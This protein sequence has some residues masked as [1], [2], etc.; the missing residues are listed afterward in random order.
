MDTLRVVIENLSELKSSSTANWWDYLID[1]GPILIAIIGMWFSYEQFKKSLSQSHDQFKKSFNNNLLQKSI[2][3]RRNEIYKKLNEFYGPL[4]Q[5][6][7][8]SQR[9]YEIFRKN[10]Y[11]KDENFRSLDYLLKGHKFNP[12]EKNLLIEIIAIGKQCEDLI[13]SKSG[14]IDNEKLRYEIL[15]KFTSHVRVLRMVSN[16]EIK[17]NPSEFESYRFPRELDDCLQEQ[18]NRLR[19]ELV[20][21]NKGL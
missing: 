2:E 21:L 18:I 10:Y 19:N 13:Y 16:N 3:D 6:R 4:L 7:K 1:F 8:Q 15:P 9:L 14:L 12:T 20:E 5:L 11:P 17:G